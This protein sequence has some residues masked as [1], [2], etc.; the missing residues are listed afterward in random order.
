[1]GVYNININKKRGITMEAQKEKT[2]EQAQL[3][4]DMSK[5]YWEL[6]NQESGQML[7]NAQRLTGLTIRAIALEAGARALKE[8]VNKGN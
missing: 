1:M 5:D 4:E 7:V 6:V 2:L 8:Q 3:L